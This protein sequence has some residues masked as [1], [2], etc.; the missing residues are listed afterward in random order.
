MINYKIKLMKESRAQI[1]ARANQLVR[2]HDNLV[3]S[4]IQMRLDKGLTQELVGERMGVSQPAV[5]A[6]ES[7]EANPTLSTIRRYALAVGATLNT[8]VIDSVTAI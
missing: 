2:D 3:S 8:E 1:E 4:L 6:F 7:Y 5:A